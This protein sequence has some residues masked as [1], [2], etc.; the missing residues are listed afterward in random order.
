MSSFRFNDTFSGQAC[1]EQ[2]PSPGTFKLREG[3]FWNDVTQKNI[4]TQ[5]NGQAGSLVQGVKVN[6]SPVTA[7]NPSVAADLMTFAMPAGF[8]NVAGKTLL[9]TAC[10]TYTTAGGQT[11]TITLTL[12]VG[13]IT[14]L[15]FVTAATT[16]SVTKNWKLEAYLTTVTASSVGTF[17]A[18][19]S[20]TFELGAG[21]AGSVATT[22]ILDLNAAVSST[23]DL[24]AAQTLKLQGLMSSSNAGNSIIQRQFIVEVLN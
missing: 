1:F 6:A 7:T 24:T 17:E 4:L 22:E 14:P 5:I 20:F 13:G 9:V 2:V 11:P 15:T 10:G 19:G 12:L 3:H 18:H 23:V 16:A 21:A 8:T